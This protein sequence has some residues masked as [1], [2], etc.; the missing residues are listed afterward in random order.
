MRCRLV[1]KERLVEK[2]PK[3]RQ[4]EGAVDYSGLKGRV[5]AWVHGHASQ[6]RRKRTRGRDDNGAAANKAPE[7]LKATKKLGPLPLK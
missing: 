7:Q 3:G 2:A 1:G 5:E 4:F 6:E